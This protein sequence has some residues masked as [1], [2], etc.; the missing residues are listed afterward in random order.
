ME[1]EESNQLKIFFIR[2]WTFYESLKWHYP[3]FMR[4][5]CSSPLGFKIVFFA[6]GVAGGDMLKLISSRVGPWGEVGLA[7]GLT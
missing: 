4:A 3:T 7:P 6:S 5:L 2:N 1:R